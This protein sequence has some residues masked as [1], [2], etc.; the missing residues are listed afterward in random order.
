MS[1]VPNRWLHDK[2]PLYT[3]INHS[4]I[5]FDF[6]S[7]CHTWSEPKFNLLLWFVV[8]GNEVDERGSPEV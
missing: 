4:E 5:E 7:H 8:S 6:F 1:M 2:L 3:Q